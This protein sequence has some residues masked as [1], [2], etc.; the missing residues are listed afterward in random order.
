MTKELIRKEQGKASKLLEI[1]SEGQ[2]I[3]FLWP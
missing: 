2:D 1:L 3:G